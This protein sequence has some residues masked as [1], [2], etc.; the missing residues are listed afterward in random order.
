MQLYQAHYKVDPRQYI[1]LS[2]GTVLN[3][4]ELYMGNFA[5][6]SVKDY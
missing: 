1:I 3:T 6:V 2:D 4:L 5:I